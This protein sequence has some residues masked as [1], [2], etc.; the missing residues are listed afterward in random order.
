M[1]SLAF[2]FTLLSTIAISIVASLPAQAQQRARAFVSIHGNDSNPCTALS[3]CKTF[4]AAHDAVLA[5]G[6]ISVLDTGG[7]G[8]L[9]IT[10][11]LSIV[12][13]GV[14]AS[15][16][17][18]SGGTGII[19]SAGA[20]DAVNLR[21]LTIDG[22]GIGGSGIAFL[23]GK[24]L[25]I[26]NCVVRNLQSSGIAVVPTASATIAV[27]KTL[28]ADNGGHGIFVQPISDASTFGIVN[29]L[30]NRVEVY[31]NGGEGIGIFVNAAPQF[32]V[33]AKIVDSVSYNN[34]NGF[35]ALGSSSNNNGD[36]AEISLLRSATFANLSG[37][38]V[39]DT[40]SRILVAQGSIDL[41]LNWSGTVIT[42]G[43]SYSTSR[44]PPD[45]QLPRE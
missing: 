7:Y 5:G 29:A 2:C 16:A 39:A 32:D 22:S 40:R 45:G 21:G 36:N 31:N 17:I 8:T 9:T 11:A 26:D 28:V 12:A 23:S 20:S 33:E 25:V 35:Y 38:I 41:D 4:Q 34:K 10:K 6:E 13:V 24:S 44:P 27:S 19:I 42:Y 3:P 30:F 18:P 43:D 1:K 14:E 37:S 15:I